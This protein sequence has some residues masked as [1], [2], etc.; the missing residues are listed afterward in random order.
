MG[1][2]KEW[3]ISFD[4]IDEV[5]TANPSL[6]GFLFGYLNE[7]ML[8]KIWFN[9]DEVSKVKKYDNH[10]RKHKGDLFVTYKGV[11]IFIEAKGLQKKSVGET[12]DGYVGKFQCDASDKRPVALPNGDIIETTCLA[13]GEFDLLAVGIFEFGKEW[14]FAFIKNE[15]LPRTTSSRYTS[16]QQKYLLKGTTSITW[17]LKPPFEPEPFR[18]IDEIVKEKRRSRKK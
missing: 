9:G 17:P 11:E 2:I 7:Y 3:K 4:E 18:L 10:D 1:V 14:R 13:V 5:V 8:K 12:D 6:R 15:N 16:E